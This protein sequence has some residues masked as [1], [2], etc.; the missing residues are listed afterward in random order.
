MSINIT[1]YYEAAT[2]KQSDA[3]AK[4]LQEK[5]ALRKQIDLKNAEI[6]ALKSEKKKKEN[7]KKQNEDEGGIDTSKLNEKIAE[8][9][10]KIA[11]ATRESEAM[12]KKEQEAV[13]V[14]GVSFER[15]EFLARI[16]DG[17]Y[18][19]GDAEEVTGMD[20][21]YQSLRIFVAETDPGGRPKKCRLHLAKQHTIEISVEAGGDHFLKA[22]RPHEL[23]W[24][25]A[26]DGVKSTPKHPRFGT[27]W[28]INDSAPKLRAFFD[29]RADKFI[30]SKTKL[31]WRTKQ[32][33]YYNKDVWK[34]EE[35]DFSDVAVS[36]TRTWKVCSKPKVPN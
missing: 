3:A 14:A 12:Q 22:F 31:S 36:L 1:T 26:S 15:H 7:L 20:G 8:L 33:D 25:P 27:E 5:E 19:C 6:S 28:E 2:K 9:E 23:A 18:K 30:L 21:C 16:V 32:D 11:A 34:D 24:I 4:A 10:A 17:V 13:A 35:E 29:K